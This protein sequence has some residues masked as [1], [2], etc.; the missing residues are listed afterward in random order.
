MSFQEE[1][2]D[3]LEEHPQHATAVKTQRIR[4][5]ENM[6]LG[7]EMSNGYFRDRGLRSFIAGT[8]GD[9]DR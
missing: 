9:E 6:V 2:T 8:E 4:R 1:S 5:L 7:Q 3:R